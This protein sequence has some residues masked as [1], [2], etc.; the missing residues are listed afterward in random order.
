[1]KVKKIELTLE[2][3]SEEFVWFMSWMETPKDFN[4]DKIKDIA[5]SISSQLTEM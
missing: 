1:M 4:Y 5:K 2:F 3:T